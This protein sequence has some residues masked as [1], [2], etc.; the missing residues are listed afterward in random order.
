MSVLGE[1]E[2]VVMEELWRR[3]SFTSVREVHESMRTLRGAA[4]T[5]VMTVLDRLAK[6]GVVERRL[7]GRAW[8][9]RPAH[10]RV[11]LYAAA[12]GEILAELDDADRLAVEARFRRPQTAR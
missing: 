6:K 5:T 1:L 4:Y 3:D 7:Q 10:S 11:D 2:M 9:Y 8:L 12:I